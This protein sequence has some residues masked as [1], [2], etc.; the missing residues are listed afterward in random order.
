MAEVKGEAKG[1]P[2]PEP[3]SGPKQLT[4]ADF[5]KRKEEPR[6]VQAV[7]VPDLCGVV[8]VRELSALEKDRLDDSMIDEKGKPIAENTRAKVFAA[9]ACDA[10]GTPLF[11]LTPADVAE[12][13]SWGLPVIQPVYD[14]A[15][16]FNKLRASDRASEKKG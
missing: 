14:A 10:S 15:L 6:R 4:A 5:R 2:A 13:G 3:K 7:D 9:C 1:E 8:Y 11:S 16:A 12:I